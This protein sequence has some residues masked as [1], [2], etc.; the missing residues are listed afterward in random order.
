[1]GVF[2]TKS[3]KNVFLPRHSGVFSTHFEQTRCARF[4]GRFSVQHE[5]PYIQGARKVENAYGISYRPIWGHPEIGAINHDFDPKLS[6]F[7]GDVSPPEV[8]FGHFF[9]IFRQ[10]R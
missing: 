10:N 4:C 7:L 2:S 8:D 1:M 5:S 6:D 3:D 9:V